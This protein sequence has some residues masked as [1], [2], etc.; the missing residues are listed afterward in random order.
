MLS[1]FNSCNRKIKQETVYLAGFEVK[2]DGD[3]QCQN[4]LK[5]QVIDEAT[6]NGI[7]AS[8]EL[9]FKNGKLIKAF[10]KIEGKREERNL[11]STEIGLELIELIPHQIHELQLTGNA[12]SYLGGEFPEGFV[13]PKFDF[14][15]PF[16]YIGKL[17]KEDEA[18]AW[19]PFD[20]NIVAPIYLNFEKLFIDYSK[21]LK[22]QVIN[23]EELK[24]AGTS[25]DE[26]QVDSKVV[27]KKSYFNSKPVSSYG[28]GFGH[29]GVP[30]WI[31]SPDFPI[32]P[33]SN[34]RMRFLG[35]IS[36][37][38]DIP[39]VRTNVKNE[40]EFMQGY[41]NKLNFW[42]AGDFYMFFQPDS[43]VLCVLIQ[44]T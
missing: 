30:A 1:F 31:Q 2:L 29:T 18:F 36:S 42:G 35:Q 19:L 22:P 13:E 20:L 5:T 6:S 24:S 44:N 16:Q 43:K 38:T 25:Y 32:C 15:A 41:F 39:T 3:E 7:W 28:N 8:I 21:P 27:Y 9:Q 11:D 37:Y 33:I 14:L 40:D 17:S 34:K 26:L 23:I 12:N 10:D 4:F